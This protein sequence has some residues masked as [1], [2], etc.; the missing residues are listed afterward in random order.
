MSVLLTEKAAHHVAGMI[1][2][3]GHGIGLRIGTRKSGC[4]G[5]AYEVDYADE[6][7]DDDQVFESHG[8]KVIIDEHSLPML[9]GMEVDYVKANVLHEGFEFH[10]PQVK[11]TCG[12][13]ES[14]SV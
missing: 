14:F 5:F 7:K 10:N 3:R 13:G 2:K 11:D 6:V 4:S 1:A 9:D 12:C 8:V